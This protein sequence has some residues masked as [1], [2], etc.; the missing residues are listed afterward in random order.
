MGLYL[1]RY[2]INFS[3]RDDKVKC[4]KSVVQEFSLSEEERRRIASKRL[5]Y[6]KDNKQKNPRKILPIQP[7]PR[8]EKRY[9]E[10]LDGW[11]S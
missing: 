9:E 7:Y 3:T 8:T 2:L 1:S 11:R 5:S 10:I 4:T 6:L